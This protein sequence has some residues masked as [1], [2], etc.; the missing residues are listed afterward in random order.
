MSG[1][2]CAKAICQAAVDGFISGGVCR[3]GKGR[4]L[5]C[6]ASNCEIGV[7]EGS[8]AKDINFRERKGF[9]IRSVFLDP[10]IPCAC[11]YSEEG[12]AVPYRGGLVSGIINRCGE[13]WVVACENREI[14]QSS[15]TAVGTIVEAGVVDGSFLSKIGLPPIVGKATGMSCGI[16]SAVA[17][18]SIVI[19]G[20]ARCAVKAVVDWFAETPAC[21]VQFVMRFCTQGFVTTAAEALCDPRTRR[22]KS[23]KRIS[24]I[25]DSLTNLY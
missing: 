10:D 16:R 1:G 9:G 5:S 11:S 22:A 2:A 25:K 3:V 6:R 13:G 23:E 7:V 24:F 12:L 15:L 21:C 18:I 4:G 20:S 17:S 8:V 14:D 19:D